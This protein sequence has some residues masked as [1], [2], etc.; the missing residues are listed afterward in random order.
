M[1]TIDDP[2]AVLLHEKASK[3]TKEKKCEAEFRLYDLIA[4]IS[5]DVLAEV[6]EGEK[7]R[8]AR[9][10]IFIPALCIRCSISRVNSTRPFLRFRALRAGSAHRIEEIVAGG[11]IYRLAYKN[12]CDVRDYVPIEKRIK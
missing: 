1:Y 9:T 5:P 2:R 11:R 8:S 12:V 3:L 6:H 4:K 7:K 10:S